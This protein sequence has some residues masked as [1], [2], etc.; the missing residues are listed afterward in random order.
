MQFNVAGMYLNVEPRFG[1]GLDVESVQSRPVWTLSPEGDM[2]AMAFDGLVV[3]LPFIIIT[4][5]N[6]WAEEGDF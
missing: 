5:G 3:L 6:V 1:V 2:K 4:L